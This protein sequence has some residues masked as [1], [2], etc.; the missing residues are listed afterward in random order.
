MTIVYFPSYYPIRRNF[1]RKG[2]Y[3]QEVDDHGNVTIR[4]VFLSKTE[5][6]K[7]INVNSTKNPF[8]QNTNS[9]TIAATNNTNTIN[10]P[11]VPIAS[12]VTTNPTAT[13]GTGIGTGKGDSPE[14]IKLSPAF[15]KLIKTQTTTKASVYFSTTLHRAF[16]CLDKETV[17]EC[18]CFIFGF[19][20]I[21]EANGTSALRVLRLFRY[22]SYLK[23]SLFYCLYSEL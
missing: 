14:L 19:V 18:I 1:F 3:I 7:L 20:Y 5:I 21:G 9:S 10:V 11:S 12:T 22:L 8:L 15:R 17:V 16:L 2:R 23:V 4:Q 13:T 6:E